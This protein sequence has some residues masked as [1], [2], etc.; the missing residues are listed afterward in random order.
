MKKI[1]LLVLFVVS[2]MML[3]AQ[4]EMMLGQWKT[5]DEKTGEIRGVIE[6]YKGD[7]NLYYGKIVK[8]FH[9][10]EEL[11]NSGFEG[12]VI[13]KDMKEKNG[14]LKDGLVYDPEHEKTY[15]GKISYNKEDNTITLRG[16]IDRLGLIGKSQTWIR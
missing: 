15:H 4:V 9:K 1:I 5:V 2:S 11:K 8:A 6:F 16:S 13:I 12:M 14:M 10:G 3:S 7:N